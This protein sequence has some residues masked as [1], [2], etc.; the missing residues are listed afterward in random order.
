MKR[1]TGI[2][3]LGFALLSFLF[4][5]CKNNKRPDQDLAS[6]ELLRGELILCSSDQFGEVS[7]AQSCSYETRET[8]DLAVSLLH[9]FE[10]EEAEKAFVQVL[11]ADP[12]CAMAYWGVAMS[13]SHSLW[14]Q[15]NNSY[16]EKGSKL[17]AIAQDLPQ[18]E[19]EK[20]YLNAISTYYKDWEN[21][22][23]PTRAK[24]YEK[25]ME[26]LYKK[27]ADDNEA[28][29]FYALA[30]RASADRTDKTYENQKKSGEILEGL[31]KDEPNHPGIA[32]YIIHNY[33]YPELAHLA[34]PTARRYAEIAPA[35]SHAQHMPSHIFTRLGLWEES[36]HSNLNSANS[37]RCYADARNM[38]GH[39]SNEL[40]AMG[41]L[42]YAYLQQG[43]NTRAEEQYQYMKTMDKVYPSNIAAIA[44]PFAAIPAR[45]ALENHRWKAAADLEFHTS[46]LQWEDFPWQSSLLHFTRAIGAV[47]LG[48]SEA[49]SKEV[50]TLEM[51]RQ[52][53]LESGSEANAN[54]V[55]I[56]IKII[57][58]SEDFSNGKKEDGLALL[59]EA[60]AMEDVIG[61]HGITPGKLIP[62]REF[63]GNLLLSDQQAEEALAV[64]EKNLLVNPNRFNGIYGAAVASIQSGQ[65]EKA[66]K[67]FKQLL[68]LTEDSASN[69]PEIEEAK[70]FLGQY[71]S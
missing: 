40:H 53:I 6:I 51:L 29:V 11:D 20:D 28:A 14:Y 2:F 5:S 7:F 64:F 23:Q 21:L 43:D 68:V 45:I 67:Y 31:F 32:H 16:L 10:Y 37:A 47:N 59:K 30:L 66:S 58:A 35:S 42:V 56:Q 69:R 33:D 55:L 4:W 15:S 71:S 12:D 46:E 57:Q 49:V 34:L 52:Q 1:Q 48:D 36:V 17:L 25:E 19:R 61:I 54:Q 60:V 24:L 27:Y 65:P 9:S 62:A 50:K 3:L 63:L 39:W 41:Y 13:I 18:G 22:D 8:F 26:K 38:E 70:A 44:Y